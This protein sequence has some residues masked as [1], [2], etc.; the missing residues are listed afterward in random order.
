M[1]N[2]M[3]ANKKK[4]VSVAIA[5][6]GTQG[7]NEAGALTALLDNGLSVGD[8]AGTS[9]GSIVAGI[10]ALT[11]DVAALKSISIS[12]DYASLI[13]F[14]WIQFLLTRYLNDGHAVKEWLLSITHNAA[15]GDCLIPLK[16]ISGDIDTG[17]I[18]VWSSKDHPDMLLAD[19]IYSSMA[20]PFIFPA[21]LDRFVDGGTVRNIPVQFLHGPKKIGIA[22]SSGFTKRDVTGLLERATRLLSML[23]TDDDTILEALAKES[24]MPIVKL[25]T[26]GYGFLDRTM[27]QEQ[28]LELFDSGYK[29]M[30][31]YLNSRSGKSWMS[32]NV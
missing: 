26:L 19:A 27:T 18:Q 1:E 3:I 23:L 25:P 28:K 5:G 13:S 29:T 15:M 6:G 9:A 32:R 7:V 30:N 24:K 31:D 16:I 10:Y 17:G 22:I 21:Y 20:L 12:A 14:S 11:K 8:L 2:N 4:L